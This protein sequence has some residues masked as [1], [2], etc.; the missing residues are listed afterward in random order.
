MTLQ[1]I[2]KYIMICDNINDV[3]T[4]ADLYKKKYHGW[5]KMWVNKS[6]EFPTNGK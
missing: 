3:C 6:I 2:K 1:V 4:N 5:K